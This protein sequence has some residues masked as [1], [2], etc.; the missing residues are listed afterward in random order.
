MKTQFFSAGVWLA[1]A[2]LSSFSPA[3]RAETVTVYVGMAGGGVED[4]VKMN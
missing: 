4:M 2:A 3:L 1:F